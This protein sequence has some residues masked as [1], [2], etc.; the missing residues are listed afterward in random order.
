[1]T[2]F[3]YANLL[4]QRSTQLEQDWPAMVDM[5][6]ITDPIEI[7]KKEISEGKVP[8]KIIRPFNY[9]DSEDIDANVLDASRHGQYY[10]PEHKKKLRKH[11]N[12]FI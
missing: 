12:L 11:L 7:A 9:G 3:E 6:N 1:M 2:R 5:K 8:L 10:T 4:V